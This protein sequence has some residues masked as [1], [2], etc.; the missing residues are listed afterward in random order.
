MEKQKMHASHSLVAD[1]FG[2]AF[3][4][5]RNTKPGPCSLLTISASRYVVRAASTNWNMVSCMA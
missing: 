4:S 3:R 2:G 1:F 5:F